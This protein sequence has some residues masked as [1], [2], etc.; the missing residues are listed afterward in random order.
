MTNGKLG[1][2]VDQQYRQI[3]EILLSYQQKMHLAKLVVHNEVEEF[4]NK[5][6]VELKQMTRVECAEAAV[7]LSEEALYVQLQ[8]N[9][10]TAIIKWA[11]KL[12][13]ELIAGKVSNYGDQYTSSEHR[14]ILAIKNNEAAQKLD[15]IRTQAQ[16][17]VDSMFFVMSHL[18]QVASSLEKLEEA[19]RYSRETS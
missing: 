6:F 12:I 7:L 4:L 14:V 8:V 9:K 11:D 2:W 1:S 15:Q 3:D 5:S 17:R 13:N 18:R 10:E 16:L 19:K